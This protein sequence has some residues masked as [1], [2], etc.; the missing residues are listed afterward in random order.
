MGPMISF[1]PS[2]TARERYLETYAAARSLTSD[3]LDSRDLPTRFGTT[4]VYRHGSAPGTPILLLHAMTSTSAGWAANVGPL[5][6]RHTV[7]TPDAIGQGGAS[8]QAAPINTAA[9]Q[10]RWVTDV[11]DAL[12]VDRVHLVGWSYGGWIAFHC[13]RLQPDRFATLTLIEPANVLARFSLGFW[14]RLLSMPVLSRLPGRY[15]GALAERY[16]RWML[17][18]PERRDP[19]V[20]DQY[21]PILD[22]LHVGNSSREYLPV[23]I[24]IPRYPTAAELASLRVPVMA[25]LGGI[26]NVHDS[27]KAARRLTTLVP[28]ARIALLPTA[29]HAPNLE[30]ADDVNRHIAEF[31][32]HHVSPM[33][34]FASLPPRYDRSVHPRWV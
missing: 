26:S 23:G 10:V 34:S 27:A 31:V 11:L 24:P 12:G 3:P 6:Q 19:D 16:S 20:V 30:R 32:D 2:S 1:F 22:L 33:V 28:S 18:H 8:T 14:R 9:D 7:Y 5:S 17:T 13:A 15:F 25:L 4:R 21:Q 29:G